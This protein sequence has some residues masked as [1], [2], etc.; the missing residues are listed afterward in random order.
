MGWCK[1]PRGETRHR[2][3][4]QKMPRYRILTTRDMATS[5][6]ADH[7]WL[8]TNNVIKCHIQHCGD[9]KQDFRRPIPHLTPGVTGLTRQCPLCRRFA[10]LNH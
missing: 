6:T 8:S 3:N 1:Q 7:V 5:P 10:W 9:S 4:H 2:K